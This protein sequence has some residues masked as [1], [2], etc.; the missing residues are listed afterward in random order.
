MSVTLSSSEFY[1][2]T[3]QRKSQTPCYQEDSLGGRIQGATYQP[4][5]VYT[6]TPYLEYTI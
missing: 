3:A 4:A 1:E 2:C 6:L 5:T